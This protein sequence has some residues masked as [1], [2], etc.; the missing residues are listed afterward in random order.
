MKARIGS[1]LL[2]F[3]LLIAQ[4]AALGHDYWHSSHKAS[5]DAKKAPKADRLCVLHDLL[6]TVLGIAGGMAQP[7]Q[8]LALAEP[9]IAAPAIVVREAQLLAPHSRDPPLTS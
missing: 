4:Q 9:A 8:F 5:A 3:A 2:V 1:A 6:G 7:P